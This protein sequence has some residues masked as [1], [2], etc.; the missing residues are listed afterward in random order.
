M[1]PLKTTIA[2]TCLAAAAPAAPGPT[3]VVWCA[4]WLDRS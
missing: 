4:H 3:P 2:A 1:N